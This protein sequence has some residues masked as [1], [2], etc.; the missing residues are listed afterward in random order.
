M[1][2]RPPTDEPGKA[3]PKLVASILR[4]DPGLTNGN[5]A[6]LSLEARVRSLIAAADGRAIFK[7]APEFATLDVATWA[8]IKNLL[9]VLPKDVLSQPDLDKIVKEERKRQAANARSFAKTGDWRD[10]LLS[11]SRGNILACVANALIALKNAQEWEG[12]LHFNES[13]F[14]TVARKSPPWEDLRQPPYT[15]SDEDDTRAAAWLQHHGVLAGKETAGQAI[16]TVA[17]EHPFHPVRDYLSALEWDGV[18]RLDSWLTLYLGVEPSDY[19]RAV[20]AKWLISGVARVLRPGCKCDCCLI[21]E[22]PQGSLKSTTLKTLGGLWFTD[23]MADLGSKDA[24]LQ[25]RGVWIIELAELDQMGRSEVSRI[26]AFMS[27]AVDRF[28]PPFGRRPIEAPRECIFA[29]TVNHTKYLK[30]ETGARRFWPVLCGEIHIPELKRDRDQLWAEAAARLEA[31]DSWWLEDKNVI[32]EATAHQQDR[33]EEDPWDHLI[34]EWVTNPEPKCDPHGNPVSLF[35]CDGEFVTIS[36]TLIH[37]IGK[38][39]DTWSPADQKRVARSL[40]SLGWKRCQKSLGRDA[41]GIQ[42]REWRYRSPQPDGD[43]AK[44]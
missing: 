20:G 42:L 4:G 10:L 15:W 9:R 23:E 37:C 39:P 6:E 7:L 44:T 22:G 38:R 13:S 33:Y 16:Q 1:I 11:D 14:D 32:Q 24:A 5:V 36:E 25:T 41:R 27:R 40:I 3:N 30:D 31:G 35:T 19:V 17:R 34:S 29:G 12:V 26:K 2:P 43:H 28:R 18:K 21:L 8:W